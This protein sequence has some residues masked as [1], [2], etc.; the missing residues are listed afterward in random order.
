M[1]VLL[2]GGNRVGK[3]TLACKFPKPILL[4]SFEPVMSG[5][6]TSVR[7]EPGVKYLRIDTVDR[8]FALADELGSDAY[9]KTH[10]IDTC[11]SL[12]QVVLTNVL[13]GKDVQLIRK[14]LVPDGKYVERAEQTRELLWAFLKLPAHTVVCGKEKDHTPLPEKNFTAK[15]VRPLRQ[16]SYVSVELGGGTAGWIQDACDCVV[17]LS[18]EKEVRIEEHKTELDDGEVMVTQTEVE[19]GDIIRRLRTKKH[20]NFFAGLRSDNP[21]V[22]PEYIDE[23]SP[24]RMYGRLMKAIRGEK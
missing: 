16:E 21:D 22:V 6:A 7:K 2:Y 24:D 5:G 17:R 3:T 23:K 11:T 13:G 1:K 19:T 4:V 14:G 18:V 9:Y 12:Q 10:V 8:A 15:M 20:P